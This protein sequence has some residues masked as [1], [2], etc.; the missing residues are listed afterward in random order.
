MKKPDI[1]GLISDGLLISG[2][3]LVSAALWRISPEL[4]MFTAGCF[5]IGFGVLVARGGTEE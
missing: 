4:G 3:V 2:A 5:C 1:R